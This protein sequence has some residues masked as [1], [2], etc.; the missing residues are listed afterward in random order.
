M[1]SIDYIKDSNK[2]VIFCKFCGEEYEKIFAE[3]ISEKT[4]VLYQCF[5]S[6]FYIKNAYR[7]KEDEINKYIGIIDYYYCCSPL[8]KLILSVQGK[9]VIDIPHYFNENINIFAE[10]FL[11]DGEY[12]WITSGDMFAGDLLKIK[13]KDFSVDWFPTSLEIKRKN[14][15]YSAINKIGKLIFLIPDFAS[16]IDIYNTECN[17]WKRINLC[18]EEGLRWFSKAIK[19]ENYIYLIPRCSENV[20]KIRVDDLSMDVCEDALKELS[21]FRRNERD[22]FCRCGRIYEDGFYFYSRA[23]NAIAKFDFDECIIKI[24]K[25]YEGEIA[26]VCEFMENKT[27]V[28][29]FQGNGC[30]YEEYDLRTHKSLFYNAP[31]W[32]SRVPFHC[33]CYNSGYLYLLPGLEDSSYK[34]NIKTHSVEKEPKFTSDGWNDA[35]EQWKYVFAENVNGEVWAFDGVNNEL[36]IKKRDDLLEI[37]NINISKIELYKGFGRKLGN[38][39]YNGIMSSIGYEEIEYEV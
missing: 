7:I 30:K 28:L 17:S 15:R 4:V 37:K 20:Y 38:E 24:V 5:K 34:I 1:I 22:D 21:K 26:S 18:G 10:T 19:L 16:G 35:G 32:H 2:K 33:S 14:R 39:I 6:D 31:I 9:K 36:R 13:K 3:K 11:D 8:E 12:F 29:V 27:V 25:K 23:Y